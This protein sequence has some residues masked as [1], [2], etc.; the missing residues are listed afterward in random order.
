L[1]TVGLPFRELAEGS[2]ISNAISSIFI[3]II[4]IVVGLLLVYARPLL[5]QV[6]SNTLRR[7]SLR[8]I[9]EK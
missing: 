4:A 9:H 8:G 7:R 5:P 1:V 6:R 2:V 3:A